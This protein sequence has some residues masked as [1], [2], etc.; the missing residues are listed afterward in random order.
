MKELSID[1]IPWGLDYEAARNRGVTFGLLRG[2]YEPGYEWHMNCQYDGQDKERAKS[3]VT[4]FI[5]G[6]FGATA[7]RFTRS[8]TDPDCQFTVH[9][10]R[11]NYS[12]R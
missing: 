12:E 2:A 11:E 9:F 3:I 6:R 8:K 10:E 5:Q 7:I 1:T 4:S